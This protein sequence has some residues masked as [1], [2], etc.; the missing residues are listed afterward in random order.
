MK[1][2][3]LFQY[4]H[5]IFSSQIWCFTESSTVKENHKTERSTLSA[6]VYSSCRQ[7]KKKNLSMQRNIIQLV[8]L[9]LFRTNVHTSYM[10]IDACKFHTFNKQDIKAIQQQMQV[11]TSESGNESTHPHM[12]F[13]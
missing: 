6:V 3:S 7:K 9:N 8:E 5:Q 13:P 1:L 12:S 11:F 2:D 10:R 4:L